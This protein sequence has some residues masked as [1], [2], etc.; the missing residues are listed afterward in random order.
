MKFIKV[1]NI[2]LKGIKVI[3]KKIWEDNKKIEIRLCSNVNCINKAESIG[4]VVLSNNG[5]K[6]YYIPLCNRC[7]NLSEDYSVSIKDLML[8]DNSM[9]I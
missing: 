1:Q 4:N 9:S 2:N 8:N 7:L 5:E 6:S 3:D